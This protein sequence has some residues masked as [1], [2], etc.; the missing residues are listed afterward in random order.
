MVF[1]VFYSV[2]SLLAVFSISLW[3]LGLKVYSHH[4]KSAMKYQISTMLKSFKGSAACDPEYQ[5]ARSV[6]FSSAMHR[7]CAPVI[8]AS[9]ELMKHCYDTTQYKLVAK[10][11]Q[12]P[13][14]QT[15]L[16]RFS[17]KCSVKSGVHEK[18][19]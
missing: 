7:P 18:G 8:Y 6:R 4:A 11:Q 10:L 3:H 16:M 9:F 19:K 1:E 5:S 14:R 12:P 17:Y 15:P 13:T 2:A